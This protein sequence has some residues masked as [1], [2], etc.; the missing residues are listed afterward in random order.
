M[1]LITQGERAKR[2]EKPNT[3][4]AINVFFNL[5]RCFCEKHALAIRADART[6]NTHPIIIR[7]L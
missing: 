4:E 1:F 5:P 7:G 3:S 6:R 2:K